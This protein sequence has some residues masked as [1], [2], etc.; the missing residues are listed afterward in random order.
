MKVS[1]LVSLLGLAACGG[2]LAGAPAGADGH[3]DSATEPETGGVVDAQASQ[4]DA[5]VSDAASECNVPQNGC[6]LCVGEWHCAP[7]VFRPFRVSGG[8]DHGCS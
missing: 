5:T 7:S 8:S 1:V 3:A 2:E 6:G 4:L